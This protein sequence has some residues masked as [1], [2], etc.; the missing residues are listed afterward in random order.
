M[1]ATLE[2]TVASR[3]AEVAR[4]LDIVRLGTTKSA[5][6]DVLPAVHALTDL[7]N[8]MVYSLAERLGGWSLDRHHHAGTHGAVIGLAMTRFG[9][10][11]GDTIFYDPTRPA[12]SQRNRV[13]EATSWIDR[14][15]PGTWEASPLCEQVFAPLRIQHAKQLRILLCDRSHLLGWFGTLHLGPVRAAHRAVLSALAPALRRRLLVERRLGL[16]GGR[17][18]ALE[19]ALDRL[20]AP[21]FALGPHD[22]I[23]EANA[24]ARVMLAQRRGDVLAAIA[25]A[26]AGRTHALRADLTPV[27]ANGVRDSW[28]AVIHA[29]TRD[30]RLDAATARAAARWRLSPRQR[31]VLALVVRGLPNATIAAELGVSQRAIELHITALFDRA[32][33]DG[34]AALVAAAITG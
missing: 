18:A 9:D 6:D 4:E 26:R 3:V 33:V 20:A 2:R 17:R 21:A 7:D 10:R 30:A 14:D 34:R 29:D 23:W 22:E 32:G 13:V 5:I 15:K 19:V 27:T 16:A 8:L 25:A 31:D 11:L 28:L 12:P 24:A 1:V